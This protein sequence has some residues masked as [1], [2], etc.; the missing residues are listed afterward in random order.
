[1]RA[2]ILGLALVLASSLT[3]SAAE[4]TTARAD[5]AAKAGSCAKFKNRIGMTDK[6]IRIGNPVDA[7]GPVPGLNLSA[8]QATRAY[9]NYFN[10]QHRICGRKVVLD[11]YDTKTDA[12]ADKAAYKTM[13]AKD[14]ASVGSLSAFDN[15]GAATAQ[16]C[17]LPDL[18]A[19]STTAAR[20]GCTTCFGAEATRAREVPNSVAD[21]LVA[22]RNAA[23]Q[24]SAMLYLNAGSAPEQAE[25]LVIAE[26]KRGMKF[27]YSAGV[28]IAAFDYAPYVQHLKSEGVQ[29]VQFVGGYQQAVRLAKAM[30]AATFKPAVFLVDRSADDPGF[31]AAGGSAVEGAVIAINSVPP[32]S[33]LAEA[34]LYRTWLQKTVPGAK[35]TIAGLY[36][37][38]AAKLFTQQARNLGAKLTRAA[39]VTRLRA[40]K[41]WTGGG[42]HAPMPVGAKHTSPCTRFLVMHNGTWVSTA[43]T[44]YRCSGITKVS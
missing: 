30:E 34:K 10:S 31:A 20:N 26:Q 4:G 3:L 39:L 24:K 36:A 18:R 27:V 9:F 40:V 6:V 28:D 23:A 21:Y 14:F 29:L 35:P 42:L 41:G 5:A 32:T 1:V 17:R 44:A 13:C 22:N 11:R 8:R 16:A 25:S 33:N 43:G 19:T 7:S 38:S 37:W 12:G 15:G 2:A